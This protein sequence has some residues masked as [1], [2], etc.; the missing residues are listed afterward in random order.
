MVGNYLA[1]IALCGMVSEMVAI[2]LWEIADP[3]LNGRLMTKEDERALLG[4]DFERLGQERRVSVLAAYSVVTPDVRQQF[5]AI[6]QTRRRYLHLWSQD[7]EQ[8]PGD[9]VKCFHAAIS[10]VVAAIGQ[11]IRDGKLILN[12]RLIP[13]LER[14]GLYEPKEGPGETGTV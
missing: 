12:P 5:D 7:H 10:V 6:R 14:S 11:D 2:L 3:Q 4:S 9:A 8:L 13:Y 1:T